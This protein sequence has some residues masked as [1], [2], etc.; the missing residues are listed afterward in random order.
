MPKER[1]QP[2]GMFRPPTYSHVVKAGDTVY[3]AGQT[4]VDEQG[5]VVGRGDI[6]AQA[7]QVFENIKKGLAAGGAD[8]S[9]LVKITVY[10]TDPRF[11]EAVAEVRRR[12][13]SA[14]ALP[15]STLVVVAGLANPDYLIEIEV[16]AV[17]G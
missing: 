12:Y 2:E 15:A 5:Q 3:L 11:R 7:T 13:L 9:D 14:D 10:V 16:I 17:I 1:I 4:P 8:F 6:T